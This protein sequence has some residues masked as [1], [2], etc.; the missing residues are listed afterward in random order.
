MLRMLVLR[1]L[2]KQYTKFR[3]GYLWTLLEPLGMALVLWFVFTQLLGGKNWACSRTS[4][5]SR[6]GSCP[7]GGLPEGSPGRQGH[8]V[9]TRYC[10]G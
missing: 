10:C 7:G 8:F 9:A 2:Q 4:C 3:L 5:S 1:D 6:W